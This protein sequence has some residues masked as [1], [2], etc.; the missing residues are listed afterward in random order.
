MIDG[1]SEFVPFAELSTAGVPIGPGVYVVSRPSRAVPEFLD[2]S[3]AGWFKGKD[4][5]L[6]VDELERRWVGETSVIYIG[7][8][9]SLRTRLS[10]YRRHGEGTPVGHWGGRM[11]WQLA[12]SAHLLVGWRETPDDDPESV[13]SA[14]LAEFAATHGA[15]PFANRK[16]GRSG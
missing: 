3:P 4:P 11:I 10:Q 8:A 1:F 13:E 12:D 16:S 7:K 15:L 6:P 9:T 14:M 2:V 5:S